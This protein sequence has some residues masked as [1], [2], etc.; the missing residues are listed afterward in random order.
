MREN[1]L[2]NRYDIMALSI[3][4]ERKK[5]KTLYESGQENT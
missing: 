5:G 1:Y 4:Y 2:S 3:L